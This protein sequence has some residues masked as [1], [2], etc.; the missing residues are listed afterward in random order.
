M[1]EVSMSKLQWAFFLGIN[2]VTVHLNPQDELVALKVSSQM[3]SSLGIIITY[4]FKLKVTVPESIIN[5]L[6]GNSEPV[7]VTSSALEEIL[8]VSEGDSLDFRSK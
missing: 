5:G 7:I 8:S 1:T 2:S 4:L 6:G 3:S